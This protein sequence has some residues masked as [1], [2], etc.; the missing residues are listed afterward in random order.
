MVKDKRLEKTQKTLLQVL[1][2]TGPEYIWEKVERISNISSKD[3]E[4]ESIYNMPNM[5]SGKENSL[6]GR[7]F[8]WEKL[9][10]KLEKRRIPICFNR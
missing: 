10:G 9:Y 1:L 2:G 3:T 4:E 6:N 8:N 7:K 5:T